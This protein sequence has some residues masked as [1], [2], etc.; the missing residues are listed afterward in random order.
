MINVLGDMTVA[1][2]LDGR[3]RAAAPAEVDAGIEQLS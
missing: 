2:L 1:C 3:Q